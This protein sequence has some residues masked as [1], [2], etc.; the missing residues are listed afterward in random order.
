MSPPIHS[1]HEHTHLC[2][3]THIYPACVCAFELT[4]LYL[5]ICDMCVHEV[6]CERLCMTLCVCVPCTAPLSCWFPLISGLSAATAASAVKQRQ[7][8]TSVGRPVKTKKTHTHLV[9]LCKTKTRR[10]KKRL[11]TQFVQ[12]LTHTQSFP[13]EPQGN[14]QQ[15]A[16]FIKVSTQNEWSF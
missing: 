13:R 3:H 11:P 5:L 1:K 9:S 7:R 8:T 16:V 4:A 2:T 15:V 6:V 14:T 10:K 12:R